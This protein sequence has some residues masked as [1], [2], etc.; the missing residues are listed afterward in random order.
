M[1]FLSDFSSWMSNNRNKF[2]QKYLTVVLVILVQWKTILLKYYS[3]GGHAACS[4]RLW[5]P[6]SVVPA[7][8]PFPLSEALEESNDGSKS[9]FLLPHGSPDRNSQPAFVKWASKWGFFLS[10]ISPSFSSN[11]FFQLK[12][13]NCYFL[14][15]LL[16]TFH[17][18]FIKRNK[19]FP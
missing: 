7:R 3:M 14:L 1:E 15:K 16:W 4:V 19:I 5:H 12:K 2:G 17:K 11:Y 9:G 18:L 13:K 10:L 8:T 6:I